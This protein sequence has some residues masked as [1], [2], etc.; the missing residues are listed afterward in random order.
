[1]NI[2]FIGQKVQLFDKEHEEAKNTH[3]ITRCKNI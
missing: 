3:K 1:M 2:K